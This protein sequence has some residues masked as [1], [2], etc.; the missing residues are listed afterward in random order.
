MPGTQASCFE[1]VGGD[2]TEW[3]LELPKTVLFLPILGF[4]TNTCF[5]I[6]EM[7]KSQSPEVSCLWQ[8]YLQNQVSGIKT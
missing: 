6:V 5:G 8:N 1:A 7:H 3:F 4:S 2:S